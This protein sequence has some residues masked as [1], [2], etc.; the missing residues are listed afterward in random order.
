MDEI[1]AIMSV[2]GI[3]C[4]AIGFVFGFRIAKEHNPIIYDDLKHAKETLKDVVNWFVIPLKR[5]SFT[6]E[7]NKHM[8]EAIKCIDYLEKNYDD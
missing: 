6:D 8:D 1:L 7:D 4:G 3:T 5:Y 2:I